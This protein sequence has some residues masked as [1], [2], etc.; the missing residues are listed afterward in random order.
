[1]ARSHFSSQAL[2]L[3]VISIAINM[4]GGQLASM[5]KLPIFLDSIGTLISAV[6]LGPVIGMLLNTDQF[7]LGI[8]DRPDRRRICTR[9]DGHRPGRRLAGASGLVSHP[10]KSRCQRRD[11]YA[12]GN[13]RRCT[14]AYCAV[15][16][17][18]R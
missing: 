4:I 12:C 18:H 6:L 13:G 7:T 11:Y 5:V 9:R 1:M 16:R 10:A 8:A 14:A 3:I 17:C 2:V 15:R